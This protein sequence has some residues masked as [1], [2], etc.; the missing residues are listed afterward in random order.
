MS[1][2]H[3]TTLTHWNSATQ[4]ILVNRIAKV[5]RKVHEQE[6]RHQE[7]AQ[8]VK[9]ILA[10]LNAQNGSPR[11]LIITDKCTLRCATSCT[12]IRPLC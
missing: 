2:V 4:R 9:G 7:G 6:V 1:Q 10:H 11:V 3:Y 12:V 5:P 8:L